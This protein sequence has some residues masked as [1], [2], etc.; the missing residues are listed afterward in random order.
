[1]G[2]GIRRLTWLASG[3]V[4]GLAV[5]VRWT[6]AR[7]ARA[8]DMPVGQL[9]SQLIADIRLRADERRAQKQT[10]THRMHRTAPGRN[11][12][13]RTGRNGAEHENKSGDKDE[14]GGD[15]G[16]EPKA[17]GSLEEFLDAIGVEVPAEELAAIHE[18]VAQLEQLG[19]AL[20]SEEVEFDPWAM[21]RAEPGTFGAPKEFAGVEI[22]L[23]D[24]DGNERTDAGDTEE[25]GGN[26]S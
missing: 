1:M 5:G 16:P 12:A 9:L 4:F 8:Q 23:E 10:R 13:A 21:D 6:L 15:I 18:Q 2:L 14:D 11:R 3:I 26:S 7:V 22:E 25:S 20:R 24:E 19:E 17:V